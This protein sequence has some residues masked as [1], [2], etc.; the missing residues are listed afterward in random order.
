MY[1]IPV[2]RGKLGTKRVIVTS[3]YLTL[4]EAGVWFK[5]KGRVGKKYSCKSTECFFKLS[6]FKRNNEKHL[7]LEMSGNILLNCLLVIYVHRDNNFEFKVSIL[8]LGSTA[9][10]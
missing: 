5:F 4:A 10:L 1:E 6:I 8:R 9:E 2:G 3:S 7:G